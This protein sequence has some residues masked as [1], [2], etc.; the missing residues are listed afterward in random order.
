[1][2]SCAE[3][4]DSHVRAALHPSAALV[5]QDK[6]ARRSPTVSPTRVGCPAGT[7]LEGSQG[8]SSARSKNHPFFIASPYAVEVIIAILLEGRRAHGCCQRR[9]LCFIGRTD[10]RGG[11]RSQPPRRHRGIATFEAYQVAPASHQRL[12][13][14]GPSFRASTSRRLAGAAAK[15]RAGGVASCLRNGACSPKRFAAPERESTG[16]NRRRVVP[17]RE[18]SADALQVRHLVV[19]SHNLSSHF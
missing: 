11:N 12:P 6:R 8:R 4:V 16:S 9:R 19:L 7:L 14:R 3:A 18:E 17:T 13:T 2:T 10:S 1:M 15:L 5:L